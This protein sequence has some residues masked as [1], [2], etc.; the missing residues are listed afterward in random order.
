MACWPHIVETWPRSRCRLDTYRGLRQGGP[1][2]ALLG[3]RRL[4]I[5]S[6]AHLRWI[7]GTT[8]IQRTHRGLGVLLAVAFSASFI[9][10]SFAFDIPNSASLFG[11]PA[12]PFD[13]PTRDYKALPV[14]DWLLYPTLIIGAV[15]DDNVFQ[16]QTNRTAALGARITPSLVAE[17]NTGIHKTTLYGFADGKFYSGA[18]QTSDTVSARGGFAHVYEAQRDLVFRFQGDY[19]RQTNVFNG[20][21][22]QF[23]VAPLQNPAGNNPVANSAPYNQITGSASVQKSFNGWFVGL[24]GST[25]Y[26][27]YD[28]AA[29]QPGALATTFPDGVVTTV[30]GRAGYWVGPWFYAFVEP[31][32]DRRRFNNA[33]LDSSGYRVTGGFGSTQIGLFRGEIFAGYQA[34]HF[35]QPGLGT[36]GGEIF[37]GRL[38]YYPTP[39]LTLSASVDETLG[40]STTAL[41]PLGT[42]TKIMTALFQSSYSLSRYWSAS[43]RFGYIR[44]EHVGSSPGLDNAWLAGIGLSYSIWRNLG[45]VIDYQFTKLDSNLP[46]SSYSR[47]VITLA[48]SYKY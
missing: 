4:A 18:A 1:N 15:Y 29:P 46:L 33:S 22:N 2:G 32:V 11:A 14:L 26:V 5:P 40:V 25:T 30:N 24:G 19:T 3:S 17:R 39:Y 48:L 47:N 36:N 44:A 38:Y 9:P 35:E 43:T 10:S 7:L 16:T 6:D 31:S 45:L 12:N 34:E 20:G 23:D 27:A 21:V 37:G 42:P 8:A 41:S 28:N 13:K